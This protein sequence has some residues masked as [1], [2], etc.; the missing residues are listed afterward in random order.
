ML[1]NMNAVC[2]MD[3]MEPTNKDPIIIVVDALPE[4]VRV[5][6]ANQ[7]ARDMDMA[8]KIGIEPHRALWRLYKRSLL[9]KTV[10]VN[11][12]IVAMF[13]VGGTFLAKKGQPWFIASPFVEDYP[14]KLAFRYR[15]EVKSMLKLFPVLE[16]LVCT[17]DTK[18]IR[19]LEILGFEFGEIQTY[20]GIEFIKATLEK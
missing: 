4:H 20:N 3:M 13:G 6:G 11:E 17:D 18:T 10:F 15:S 8:K 5:L 2:K 12:E 14:V 16:D 1:Y 9:C 7:R 19:L